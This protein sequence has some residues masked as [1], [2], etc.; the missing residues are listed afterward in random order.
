M[1]ANELRIGSIVRIKDTGEIVRVCGL[2]NKKICY[3]KGND[4]GTNLSRRKYCE[5]EP[6][7]IR[8]VNSVLPPIPNLMWADKTNCEDLYYYHGV[9]ITDL[10]ELQNIHFALMGNELKIEI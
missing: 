2:T 1:K 5:I 9:V 3:H 8:E 7:L 4:K 10:H 6:V